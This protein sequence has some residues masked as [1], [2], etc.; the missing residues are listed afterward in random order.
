MQN[1][2][3]NSETNQN[4]SETNQNN[5]EIKQMI[6][7]MTQQKQKLSKLGKAGSIV[8]HLEGLQI[9]YQMLLNQY[10]QIQ[11][12][13]S[14]Y[15]SQYPPGNY[16]QNGNFDDPQ[17]ANDSWIQITS[18]TTVPSWNFNNASL[19]N[20]SSAM[21]YP[22]PYPKGSQAVSI[23]NMDSLS[24]TVN[25]N[26]GTYLLRFSACGRNCCD[27]SN[28]SNPIDIQ[29]NGNTIYQV[30]PPINAW[31]NYSTQF[32]I[33]GSGNTTDSSGNSIT[34]GIVGSNTLSFMGTTSFV[35]WSSTDRSTA[36][37][38]IKL[39]YNGLTGVAGNSFIGQPISHTQVEDLN[40]CIA[41]CSKL[42]K[43][44]G[45]T[46][47]DDQKI[48]ALQSGEGNMLRS[49]NPS[50]YAII[51]ANLT[52]LQKIKNLNEQLIDVNDE[53]ENNINQGS[54]V[55]RQTINEL[56]SNKGNINQS[57]QK[58]NKERREILKMI[59]EFEKLEAVNRD[60]S[61]ASSTNYTIFLFLLILSLIIVF[62]L[63]FLFI[64]SSTNSSSSSSS[65]SFLQKGG[66]YNNLFSV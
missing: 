27:N 55:Y 47:N 21:G 33:D 31:K 13:Y 20:N 37:Q 53:I 51:S 64:S 38:N 62:L 54:S 39:V 4:N 28:E 1:N 66:F 36:I 8:L 32:T 52:Y 46:Y 30:Q 35:D 25:L 22:T 16:I 45:A 63:I 34:G 5:S 48:C 43:C 11:S 3:N 17:I 24:Q 41:S 15:L 12:E 61:L 56:N 57:Y 18:S 49:S 26:E 60:S 2:Q 44:S 19:I 40:A 14:Q 29:L 58:L 7:N 6:N 42:S 65:S 10:N 59:K 23:Q 50:N 9:K